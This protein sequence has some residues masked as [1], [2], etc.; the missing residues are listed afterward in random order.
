MGSIYAKRLEGTQRELGSYFDKSKTVVISNY[1]W[2][3]LASSA[4]TMIN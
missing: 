3:V 4:P 2:S 1:Q